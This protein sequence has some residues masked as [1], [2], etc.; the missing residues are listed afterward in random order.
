MKKNKENYNYIK[1]IN[2]ITMMTENTMEER[3]L[4][5]I[6]NKDFSNLRSF[7]NTLAYLE[8]AKVEMVINQIR[9]DL[10]NYTNYCNEMPYEDLVLALYYI[11]KSNTLKANGNI[12]KRIQDIIEYRKTEDFEIEKT[13]KILELREN[14]DNCVEQNN[15]IYIYE[16]MLTYANDEES[17]Y[18]RFSLESYENMLEVLKHA[19]TVNDIKFLNSVQKMFL[20][21]EKYLMKDIMQTIIK[22]EPLHGYKYA[23]INLFKTLMDG[24]KFAE[25]EEKYIY[26]CIEVNLIMK[27]SSKYNVNEWDNLKRF[28]SLLMCDFD[29]DYEN[30]K[31]KTR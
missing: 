19:I 16:E 7:N 6:E 24:Y 30:N 4:N 26:A 10:I 11:N 31:N 8:E 23:D 21:S 13:N 17:M 14:L 20:Q 12:I 2:N 25:K 18:K 5:A 28:K 29:I 15:V 9:N 1:Q 3:I 27:T 22:G